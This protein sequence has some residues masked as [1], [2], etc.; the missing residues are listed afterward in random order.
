MIASAACS[1][2]CWCGEL[3][4]NVT[5]GIRS[6]TV[7]LSLSV[8]FNPF[9]GCGVDAGVA[10]ERRVWNIGII[11]GIY[12]KQPAATDMRTNGGLCFS[13]IINHRLSVLY[14]LSVE[15]RL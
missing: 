12:E 9:G 1:S 5:F 10:S 6:L 8:K 13:C 15:N 14:H 2:L 7:R 4:G 3:Q 11:M